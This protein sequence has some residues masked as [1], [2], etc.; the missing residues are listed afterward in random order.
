[1]QRTKIAIFFVTILN[2]SVF[3]QKAAKFEVKKVD[4]A[5]IEA[6]IKNPES[7]YY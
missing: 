7:K 1:M 6:E 2:I 3:A 4:F 5:E